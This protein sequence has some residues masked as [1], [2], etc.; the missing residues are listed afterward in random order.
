[1][2]RTFSADELESIAKQTGFMKRK[3]KVNPVSFFDLLLYQMSSGKSKSLNQLSIEFESSTGIDVSKQGIDKRFNDQAINFLKRLIEKQLSIEISHEIDTQWLSKFNRVLIK[4]GT[5]FDL[6]DDY[7]DILPGSGG[8]ASKAGACIQFEFD[9]KKGSII[10]LD[11]TPANRPDK[12]EASE[13]LNDV[14]KGDLVIRDLG[15]HLYK[16]FSNIIEREAYFLSRLHPKANV[17]TLNN[18]QYQKID[19][20]ALYLR[21]NRHHQKVDYKNVF[22]GESR[23]PAILTIEMVPEDVYEK[24]LRNADKNNRKKGRKTSEEYR[25]FARF[26]FFITNIPENEL[27]IKIMSTLYR[28][29]WQ[30]ELIFKVWKSIFGINHKTKMKFKR[31]LCIL[32]AKLLI[33]IVY[34]NIIMNCRNYKHKLEGELLSFNKCFK[35]LFDNTYRLRNL[36]KG[37]SKEISKLLKWVIKIFSKK[38]QLEARKNSKCLVEIISLNIYKSIEYSYI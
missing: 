38:H 33:M 1:L 16:S 22:I 35:T 29:R 36:L 8:C 24:R 18:G 19:F 20:K 17:Y 30:I 28:I 31:W 26:S 3:S 2:E 15:Y 27:P 9:M 11:V 14:Q 12:K 32:Y 23:V 5:R 37:G 25:I 4:D 6:Q 10:Q 7:K 34:W 13:V 21:M